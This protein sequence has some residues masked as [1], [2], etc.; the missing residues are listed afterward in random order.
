MWCLTGWHPLLV[1]GAAWGVGLLGLV[2]LLWT[3]R[4]YD[5]ELGALDHGDGLR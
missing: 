4:V 2:G 3:A 5:G 1:L